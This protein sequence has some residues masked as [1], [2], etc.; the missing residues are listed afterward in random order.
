MLSGS[1]QAGLAAYAFVDSAVSAYQAGANV[2]QAIGIGIVSGS[3]AYIGAQFGMDYMGGPVG[4]WL[5]S[6][7]IGSIGASIGT[8]AIMGGDI[9]QAAL[10]GTVGGVATAI[11]GPI[12]GGG[13]ASVASGGKFGDGALEG[14]Y[15]TI[16]SG[17][18][19]VTT[20]ISRGQIQRATD[21][22]GEKGGLLGR[23]QAQDAFAKNIHLCGAAQ[24][25]GDAVGNV[26]NAINEFVGMRSQINFMKQLFS[27]YTDL[28]KQVFEGHYVDIE[29]FGNKYTGDIIGWDYYRSDRQSIVNPNTTATG[30]VR[31]HGTRPRQ[32]YAG[33]DDNYYF[34]RGDL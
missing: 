2:F 22:A 18:V 23:K 3:S 31:I 12:V 27:L 7:V 9:G 6:N 19:T 21:T 20:A 26:F 1:V 30:W 13:V 32:T 34:E 33:W 15:A 4:A 10:S 24:N 16:G 8:A 29:I 25:F 11:A 5:G 17:A 28:Q 14:L